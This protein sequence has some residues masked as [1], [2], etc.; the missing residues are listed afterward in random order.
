MGGFIRTLPN[1]WLCHEW[2]DLK[3]IIKE[4]SFSGLLKSYYP[5]EHNLIPFSLCKTGKRWD[6]HSLELLLLIMFWSPSAMCMKI[7]SDLIN[8]S[9]A[10][11]GYK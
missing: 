2:V 3:I 4:F 7:S 5:M 10:I 11:S 1:S 9:E 6:S 8:L